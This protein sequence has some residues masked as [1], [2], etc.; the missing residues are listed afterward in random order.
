MSL[1][2]GTISFQSSMANVRMKICSIPT[3]VPAECIEYSSPLCLRSRWTCATSFDTEAVG[4]P[5]GMRQ[6]SAMQAGGVGNLVRST[7]LDI[8]SRGGRYHLFYDVVCV[9]GDV[10]ADGRCDDSLVTSLTFRKNAPSPVTS[11]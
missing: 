6:K 9:V 10:A 4:V 8:L 2:Q 3:V 11:V 5:S 7:V 1:L